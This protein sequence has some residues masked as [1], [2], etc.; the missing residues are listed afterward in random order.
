MELLRRWLEKENLWL[1]AKESVLE[2]PEAGGCNPLP[3]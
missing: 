3:R 1:S 2:E